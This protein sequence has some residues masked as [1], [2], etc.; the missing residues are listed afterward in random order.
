MTTDTLALFDLATTHHLPIRFKIMSGASLLVKIGAV[1]KESYEKKNAEFFARYQAGTLDPA[2]FLA[3]A[4]GTLARFPRV[5][6]NRWRQRYMDEIICPAI[7]PSALD[8]VRKHQNNNDLVAIVT[9]TN[10]FVTE[11]IAK[12][13]GVRHLI[14]ALPEVNARGRNHRETDRHSDVGSG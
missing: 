10:R 2:E 11:P 13:F 5:Q 3:F 9:A 4:L 14:A 12:A 8:L 7:R 1:D 6:L